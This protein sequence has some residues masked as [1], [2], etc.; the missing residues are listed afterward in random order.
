MLVRT[1]RVTVAQVTQEGAAATFVDP[2][3]GTTDPLFER[4]P[5]VVRAT[6]ALSSGPVPVT[7][8]VAHLTRASTM[9]NPYIGTH[10]RAQ[11]AAQAEFIA[12][13]AQERQIAAPA[14]PLVVLGDL[15]APAFTDGYVD[16]AGT[17]AGSPA[18]AA[19]VSTTTA[20]LVQPN[21]EDA[22]ADVPAASRYTS[23]AH[24]TAQ[25][26]H[27]VLVNAA[28]ADL[29]SRAFI[30]HANADFP[31]ALGNDAS[32]AERAASTDA[33]VVYFEVAAAEPPPPPPTT[34]QEI[35]SQ[36]RVRVRTWRPFG[37][38]RGL[39]HALV[40]VTNVSRKNL[41]GPFVLGV[42][43]LPAGAVVLNATGKIAAMPAVRVPWTPKLRPGRS[44]LRLGGAERHAV[45]GQP[46][47]ARLRR[48]GEVSHGGGPPMGRPSF[49]GSF[50]RG[51]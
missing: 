50:C 18:A 2:F 30:A 22:L 47:G 32:R 12:G 33:A 28:A 8:I 7:A 3:W 49:T 48:A 25:Q 46:E 23:T 36:V 26:L 17:I 43:G 38:H 44:F 37:R 31:E 11:R 29:Q 40:E 10:F 19:T 9:A 42:Y 20:D 34:P 15:D 16:V 35:T 45:P 13:L 21:L 39:A 5:L 24:G 1:S 27:H 41:N 14:E 6:V 51:R 4:P